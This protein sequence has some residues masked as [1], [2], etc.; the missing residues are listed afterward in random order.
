VPCEL[1]TVGED[2]DVGL[3]LGRR[4]ALLGE[5]CGGE[6]ERQAEGEGSQCAQG[7]ASGVG[8]AYI[9]CDSRGLVYRLAREGVGLSDDESFLKMRSTDRLKPAMGIGAFFVR[10]LFVFLNDETRRTGPI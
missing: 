10:E 7:V 2:E 8:I 9:G 5:S 4:C 1:V 6:E 3:G